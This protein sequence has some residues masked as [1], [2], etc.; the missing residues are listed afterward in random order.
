MVLWHKDEKFAGVRYREHI[1]RKHGLR[2]DRC[3]SIRYKLDGKG[4][5]EVVGWWSQGVTAQKAYDA[6]SMLLKNHKSGQGSRTLQETR[7]QSENERA[8]KAVALEQEAKAKITVAEF[9]HKHYLP[10]ILQHKK[11]GT[12]H[13]EMGLFK[14]WLSPVLATVPLQA[15]T[16]AHI[17][18]VCLDA[19]KH[20]RSPQTIR[21]IIA[22]FSQLW[23]MAIKKNIVTGDNPC[24]LVDKP[25]QD[26][27][28]MRFLTP[29]EANLLLATLKERSIDIHDIALLALFCGLRAGEIHSLTWGDLNWLAATLLIRDSKNKQ[30][31][32]VHIT[33]QV[34]TMLERRYQ[35]QPT[36]A[37]IFPAN[38]GE[39]R[40]K[41]SK[42]FNRVV[43][44][45][46]F[47]NT[48]EFVTN[49]AGERVPVEIADRRQRLVF[50]CLRH[51]F[52]SW[53]VQKGVPLYTVAE[54]MGHKTLAM[55]TRYSHLAPE[56]TRKAAMQ[57]EGVLEQE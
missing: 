4:K 35:N 31:R 48:G 23:N 46:G 14:N 29:E 7:E 30:N 32:Q 13:S 42:T 50:H 12:Y 41:V 2:P 44:E 39:V 22:L 25:R 10:V 38:N 17:E 26:S 43:R 45:L 53:L 3:Y 16:P 5:E 54:L 1:S 33:R 49:A 47:N 52:A 36:T 15:V 11:P 56:H 51:T 40:E 55:T 37:L 57:L 20:N 28:R 9:W 19:A 8:M 21:H 34:Q 27:R 6:L 24:R 18:A